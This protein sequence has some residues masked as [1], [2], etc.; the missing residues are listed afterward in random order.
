MSIAGP[1]MLRPTNITRRTV[2]G[3]LRPLIAVTH[4]TISIA[5]PAML[6]PTSITRRM[7]MGT[8]FHI[9]GMAFQLD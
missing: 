2:M 3:P 9:T 4:I 8:T 1:A 7:V 6:H 5:R